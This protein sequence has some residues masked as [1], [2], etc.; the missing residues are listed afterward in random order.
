[1]F[2]EEYNMSVKLVRELIIANSFG[3]QT[4]NIIESMKRMYAESG[5][6]NKVHDYRQSDNRAWIYNQ[7]ISPKAHYERLRQDWIG[8]YRGM[9]TVH[10]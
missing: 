7:S 5:S 3:N 6:E 9:C 8:H 2:E 1:M 4:V 10:L